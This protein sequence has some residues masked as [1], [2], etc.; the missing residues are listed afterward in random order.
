M[1]LKVYEYVT[2]SHFIVAIFF[3]LTVEILLFVIKIS[4]Y[5]DLGK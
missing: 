3:T 1:L 4:F 2:Y 5:S